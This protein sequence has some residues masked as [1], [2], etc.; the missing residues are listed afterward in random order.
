MK[1]I[2]VA[3]DSHG[4]NLVFV[5]DGLKAYPLLDAIAL[6]QNGEIDSTHVVRKYSGTYIRTNKSVPKS[7]ELK[8][9]SISSYQ[10]FSRI[11]DT[12]LGGFK[13]L[14]DYW[15]RYQKK[16]DI[17]SDRHIIKINGWRMVT[18]KIVREKLQSHKELIFEAT[19]QFQV[20]PYLLGGI[21]IDEIARLDPFEEIINLL[22]TQ[23]IGSNTSLGIAQIMIETARNLIQAEYYNPNPSDPKLSKAQISKTSREY[24]AKYV[25]EPKHN[26]FFATA[27]MRHLIDDWKKFVD[28]NNRPD[29]IATLYHHT[30]KTPHSNPKPNQR[31]LQIA[32]EF[33]N[34]AKTYLSQ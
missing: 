3:T 5:S 34:L 19:S 25:T 16:L 23:F 30:Y 26:I 29:I 31:G 13:P 20:D 33:Y 22:S 28:L 2:L 14:T 8:I 21:I 27:K 9:L 32:G 11:H 6:A 24:L 17:D 1:I 4:K 10:L 15:R 12:D 7:R 18:K